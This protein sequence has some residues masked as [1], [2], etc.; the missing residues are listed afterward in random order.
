MRW[1]E[2]V[3]CGADILPRLNVVGFLLGTCEVG[4]CQRLLIDLY[5]IGLRA[6]AFSLVFR[7]GRVRR[8]MREGI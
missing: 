4:V 5:S 1:N 7:P 6:R 8:P 2:H 3:R